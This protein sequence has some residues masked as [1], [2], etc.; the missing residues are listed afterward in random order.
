VQKAT[1]A[2]IRRSEAILWGKNRKVTH[3]VKEL[4]VGMSRV[5]WEGRPTVIGTGEAAS[6]QQLHLLPEVEEVCVV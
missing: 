1:H 2:V 4:V 3:D 6:G 5:I